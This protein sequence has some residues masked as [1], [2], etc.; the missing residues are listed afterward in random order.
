VARFEELGP[1]YR[2][3]RA[4]I[5]GL[6][7]KW[8]IEPGEVLVDYTCGTKTMSAALVLAGLEHAFKH[9]VRWEV[10]VEL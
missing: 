9:L 3:L 1:C 7:R 6:L 8:R 2:A 4:E 10:R 5:P